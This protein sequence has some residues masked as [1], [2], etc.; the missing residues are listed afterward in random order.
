MVKI[1]E[2]R[3]Q[4]DNGK[5]IVRK[6]DN[7]IMGEAICLGDT[8]MID[9][10]TEIEYTEESYKEFY[11]SIGQPIVEEKEVEDKLKNARENNY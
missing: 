4:A 1:D 9:N 7:F 8:D 6:A 11:E 5:F 10:Y 3:Y 2:Y